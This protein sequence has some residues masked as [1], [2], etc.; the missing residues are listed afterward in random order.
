MDLEI[1]IIGSYKSLD[2]LKDNELQEEGLFIQE[3]GKALEDSQI[4]P[5]ANQDKKIPPDFVNAIKVQPV[6]LYSDRPRS[7]LLLDR[8]IVME[9]GP[10][11]NICAVANALTICR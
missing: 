4:F 10:L 7:I 2:A 3:P 9:Y 1:P 5:Y 11:E 6:E 8:G